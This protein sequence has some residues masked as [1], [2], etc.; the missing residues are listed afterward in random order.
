MELFIITI[1]IK[2]FSIK[3]FGD[4]EKILKHIKNKIDTNNYEVVNTLNKVSSEDS[5]L[6]AAKEEQR[7]EYV[8]CN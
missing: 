4:E 7:Y 1:Q 2:I 5:P 6:E 3:F 8:A